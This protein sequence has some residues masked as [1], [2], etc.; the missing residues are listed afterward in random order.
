MTLE[1]IDI[2]IAIITAIFVFITLTIGI[3][4][5]S[6]FFKFHNTTFIYIGIAWVGMSFPLIPDLL[7]PLFILTQPTISDQMLILI[8]SVFNVILLPVFVILWLYALMDLIGTEKRIKEFLLIFSIVLSILYECFLIYFSLTDIFLLGSI[9]SPYHVIWTSFIDILL[10]SCILVVLIT[11][12]IFARSSLKSEDNLIK[13]KGK[14]LIGAFI[15]FFIGAVIDAIFITDISN[16][17][18]RLFLVISSIS[19]YIGFI[20]PKWIRKLLLN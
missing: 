1:M 4:I 3:R 19:F 12:F 5:A 20:L 7:E 13:L 8:Y 17:I 10:L 9:S 2:T 14:I 16:I 15:L 6:K 18:A 11:G